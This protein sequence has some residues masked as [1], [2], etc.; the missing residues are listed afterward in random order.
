[1]TELNKRITLVLDEAVSDTIWEI[2]NTG[3]IGKTP[4]EVIDFAL[5]AMF[6]AYQ[7]KQ[8]SQ[9]TGFPEIEFTKQA[10]SIFDQLLHSGR[11]GSTDGDVI[12]LA[13]HLLYKIHKHD[14]DVLLVSK[15]G[16]PYCKFSFIS[17]LLTW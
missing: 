10:E 14:C 7:K 3:E 16:N 17:R 4:E 1:M 2:V 13:L 11:F 12:S 15:D 8:F 5:Y 9:E 6:K